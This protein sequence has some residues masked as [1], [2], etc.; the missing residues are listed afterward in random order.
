MSFLW[1]EPERPSCDGL[2]L[3]T[4]DKPKEQLQRS[5]PRGAGTGRSDGCAHGSEAAETWSSPPEMGSVSAFFSLAALAE[6]AAMENVHRSVA[7]SLVPQGPGAAVQRPP[8]RSMDG[9]AG[10]RPFGHHVRLCSQCTGVR[11]TRL[12]GTS[13]HVRSRKDRS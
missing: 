11:K 2:P 12:Q 9:K 4:D 6:V 7:D 3:V 10:R 5:L 1:G 13:A 8:P